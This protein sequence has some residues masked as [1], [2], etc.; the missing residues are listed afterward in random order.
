MID[1]RIKKISEASGL[2]ESEV[3][4]RIEKK[5]E[6]AAGLLTDHGAVY[7]LEKEYGIGSDGE[8]MAEY[9]KFSEVKPGENSVSILGRVKE[10]RPIKKFQT[11]KRSGQLARIIAEDSSGEF[12]IVLW[13][14]SAEMAGK[15]SRGSIIALRNAYSKEGLDKLP[16]IHVGS[17]SRVMID[18]KNLDEKLLKGLPEFSEKI[19]AI[20]DLKAGD[21][22]TAEGRIR[23]LYPKTEF[24][25][26]DGRVGQRASMIIEDTTGTTR[27]ALWDA[28]ADTVESFKEGDVIKVEGGQVR[29]GPRGLEIHAGNR[30]RVLASDTKIDLPEIKR[31][32]EKS[33]KISEIGPNLQN[34]S[35]AGRVMR[36][37]PIKEFSSGDR[38]GRLASVIIVDDTGITRAVLWND[39]SE[40]VKDISPG[41][42]ILLK[43]AYSKESLSGEPE[44][45]LSQRGSLH[46]NPEGIEIGDIVD[47]ISKNA[48]AKRISEIKPDDRNVAVS[49]K[50]S[51]V[52]ES[53][54]VFEVCSECGAKV[55]NVA[56]E[57]M[58]DLCGEVTPAYGMVASCTISDGSEIRAVFYRHLA[59]QLTGM[60][61]TDALNTIGQSGDELEPAR[62]AA[63][64]LVGCEISVTGDVRYNEYQDKLEIM[65]TSV[66]TSGS[67]APNKSAAED[68]PE[69]PIDEDIEEDIEI[70]E[71]VLDD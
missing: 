41:D 14:K 61:V 24:Q 42:I 39:K 54:M 59:E 27:V 37:L 66:K 23:Y 34:I 16:E 46:I 2:S 53:H 56:G 3:R 10:V 32:E 71:V 63:A 35:I 62:Q 9:K 33:Y 50:I 43:N 19:T 12:P 68:I 28:N 48:T 45:H 4:E 70:E 64:E 51:E 67:K 11:P 20:K 22:A 25:R 21:I 29:E 36:A 57:W 31:E 69:E 13:D 7:A 52:D 60:S 38:S 18:P 47:L 65:A 40:H 49:G 26:Q 1:Q 8:A 17:L 55:E 58:C 15:I 30:G 6:D 44:V 5:K